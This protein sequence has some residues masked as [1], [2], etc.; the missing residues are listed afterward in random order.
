MVR[1]PARNIF[2]RHYASGQPQNCVEHDS[3]IPFCWLTSFALGN[4]PSIRSHSV[5]LS[6]YL[7][8][9]FFISW[10][11][12][13]YL[14]CNFMQLFVFRYTIIIPKTEH[15]PTHFGSAD[16]Y[17]AALLC[18]ALISKNNGILLAYDFIWW[19]KTIGLFSNTLRIRHSHMLRQHITSKIAVQESHD[20]TAGTICSRTV[21]RCAGFLGDVVLYHRCT[22]SS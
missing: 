19:I 20:L 5:S 4:T 22:T 9:I 8:D 11:P 2:L 18:N 3:F 21:G 15:Q 13:I 10:L 1:I 7:F 12:P 17:F 16:A 14:L 6:S